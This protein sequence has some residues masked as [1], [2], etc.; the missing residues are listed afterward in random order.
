MNRTAKIL[1]LLFFLLFCAYH[2][3]AQD[4]VRSFRVD[5][6][7]NGK[8]PVLLIPGFSCP[9][10]VWEETVKELRGDY[11]FYTIT[12]SGFGG[13]APQAR[14][15]LQQ[16]TSDLIAYLEK[17][18]IK[19][20]I[21]IGHSMGGTTALSMAAARPGLFSKLVIVDAMPCLSAFFNPNFK[22]DSNA[23]CDEQG[24]KFK[25][26]TDGQFMQMQR[27]GVTQLVADTAAQSRLVG[28]AMHGDRNTLGSIY[29]Q[30]LNTDLRGKLSGIQVPTLLLLEPM[31][32]DNDAQVREQYAGL[33][34][35]K[36]KYANKGLHFIM[37]DDKDWF[38][39]EVQQFCA[40]GF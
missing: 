22:A 35:L 21:V 40:N 23:R 34:N 19:G 2:L 30:L 6:S 32:K 15:S 3:F 16:W 38:M 8:T 37:Y 11:R 27:M 31:F 25:A 4:G 1:A 28:W 12:F 24:Q 7:G 26:V 36:I 13:Q 17:E 20:A 5:K 33:S 9:G 39:N 14:P 18:K 29:C 10:E